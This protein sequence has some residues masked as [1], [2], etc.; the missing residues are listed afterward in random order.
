M[1]TQVAFVIAVVCAGISA[2]IAHENGRS[3]LHFGLLG[4]LT[5]PIGVIIAMVAR[6]GR[7]QAARDQAALESY[8]AE[9]TPPPALP[10]HKAKRRTGG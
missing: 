4:L 10:S 3:A 1:T 2:F 6:S 8:R 9:Q 5:G 7:A